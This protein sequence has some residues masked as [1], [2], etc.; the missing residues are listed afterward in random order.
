MK[1]IVSAILL[2]CLTVSLFACQQSYTPDFDAVSAGV[3]VDVLNVGNADSILI[4]SN[5]EAML[6]DGGET[7]TTEYVLEFLEKHEIFKLDYLIATHPHTDHIGGLIGVAEK[8]EIGQLI[9]P[10]VEHATRT[11]EKF[12]DTLIAKEVKAV[13][14]VVGEKYAIGNAEFVIL[15]PNSDTYKNLND[16]SV[17]IRLVYENTSFLFT[18]DAE[19]V[20]ENE[21]ID[22]NLT[23]SSDFLKVGHHGSD[24]SSKKRFLQEIRPKF[25]V[26]STDGGKAPSDKVLQ[27]LREVGA[28]VYRTDVNGIVTAI[29]DG[30]NITISTEKQ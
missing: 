7:A 27:R 19:S 8:I 20:S 14:P 25:A 4:R 28:E 15:A 16:Y 11:Y 29:S 9:M 6:I 18:G 26:I 22:N 12:I 1:R 23:L 3:T 2:I 30:N 24:T 21:I 13:V 17:V 5:G 10:K